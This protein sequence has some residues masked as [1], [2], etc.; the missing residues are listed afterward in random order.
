M[1]IKARK[2]QAKQTDHSRQITREVIAVLNS[3]NDERAW[4]KDVIDIAQ[5][6][7]D[8]WLWQ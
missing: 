7:A 2:D 3:I 6:I 1:A 4:K 5:A 8:A